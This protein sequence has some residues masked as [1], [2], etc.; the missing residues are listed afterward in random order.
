MRAPR[1]RA[2]QHRGARSLAGHH[3]DLRGIRFIV[4]ADPMGEARILAR[5]AGFDEARSAYAKAW[6]DRVNELDLAGMPGVLRDQYGPMTALLVAA[7]L[8]HGS[9]E[10]A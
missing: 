9:F 2:G 7:I 8:P 10:G 1:E 4:V 6:H 5:C 3:P